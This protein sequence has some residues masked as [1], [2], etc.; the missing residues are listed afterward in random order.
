MTRAGK[1]RAGSHGKE[2][3]ATLA[4]E[5]EELR[6]VAFWARE[7]T[8]PEGRVRKLAILLCDFV[9]SGG[10][11]P[12]APATE[13]VEVDGGHAGNGRVAPEET[14]DTER[15]KRERVIVNGRLENGLRTRSKID[16]VSDCGHVVW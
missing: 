11:V 15:V 13:A 9:C 3:G 12:S 7:K 4:V 2:R 5:A 8:V 16:K 1:A 10:I 6:G 14:C